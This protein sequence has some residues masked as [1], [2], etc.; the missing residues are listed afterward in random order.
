MGSLTGS[1]RTRFVG[2]FSARRA[3]S[4]PNGFTVRTGLPSRSSPGTKYPLST[5]AAP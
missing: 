5:P 2:V 4:L 3:L 1:A